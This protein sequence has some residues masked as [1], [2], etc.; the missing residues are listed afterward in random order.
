MVLGEEEGLQVDGA[1]D[2]LDRGVA[3]PI[4]DL[5]DFENGSKIGVVFECA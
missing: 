3:N 1:V 5:V 2:D 4:V